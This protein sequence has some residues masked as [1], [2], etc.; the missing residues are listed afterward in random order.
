MDWDWDWDMVVLLA[1]V[2]HDVLTLAG[3]RR[4][5]HQSAN[6]RYCFSQFSAKKEMDFLFLFVCKRYLFVV[7]LKSSETCNLECILFDFF[8]RT[9]PETN[10]QIFKYL[11]NIFQIFKSTPSETNDRESFLLD[12]SK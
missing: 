11:L 7:C 10:L 5:C 3:E 9:P 4:L 8:E 1:D 6:G 2:L 12:I